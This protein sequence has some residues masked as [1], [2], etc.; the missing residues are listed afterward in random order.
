MRLRRIEF[1]RKSHISWAFEAHCRLATSSLNH[2]SHQIWGRALHLPK[3]YITNSLLAAKSPRVPVSFAYLLTKS[4]MWNWKSLMK[5]RL[6]VQHSDNDDEGVFTAGPGEL[7]LG[8]S[9]L[10]TFVFRAIAVVDAPQTRWEWKIR[11]Q[12]KMQS[13]RFFHCKLEFL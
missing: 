9:W 10:K 13:S 12:A 8:F 7:R 2:S 11:L 5:V 6:G 1:V 3:F 4:N